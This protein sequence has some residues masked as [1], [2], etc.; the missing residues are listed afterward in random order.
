MANLVSE[1]NASEGPL[2]A[3]SELTS[4]FWAFVLIAAMSAVGFGAAWLVTTGLIAVA[5]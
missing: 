2:P 5:P 1:L 4:M 3:A